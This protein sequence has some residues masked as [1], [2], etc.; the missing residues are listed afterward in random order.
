MA[1]VFKPDDVRNKEL[2][3]YGMKECFILRYRVM[4]A[5]N[6]PCYQLL[7]GHCLAFPLDY[8]GHQNVSDP[9]KE[10]WD[11]RM[12]MRDSVISV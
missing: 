8:G 1:C 11:A 9:S 2:D 7:K 5:G 10:G 6:R 3:V 4:D 12:A